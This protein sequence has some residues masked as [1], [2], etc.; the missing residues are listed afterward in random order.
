MQCPLLGELPLPFSTRRGWPHTVETCT[1]PSGIDAPRVTIVTPSFNQGQF[2]EETIR[3]VLLQGYPNLE[4]IV[5][6]GGSTDNSVEIIRRYERWL[7][8]WVSEPD[9]GQASAINKGLCQS[10]GQIMAWLNSDDCLQPGAIWQIVSLFNRSPQTNLVCGYRQVIDAKCRHVRYEA[11]VKPDKFS[12][13]RICYIPQETVYW[14][15]AVWETVGE[16]DES[17]Q[18][19]LDFDYWQRVLLAGYHFDL[20]PRFI[21]L[22]RLHANAKGERSLDVRERELARIHLRYLHSTK[23]EIELR[24]EIS[25]AWWRRMRFLRLLAGLR[26]L[27]VPRLADVVVDALSLKEDAV[28]NQATMRPH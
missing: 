13:S 17:Y 16:L 23:T 3:S 19:A 9:R 11:Y 14:R 8:H 12:L 7:T 27:H 5:I 28:A 18:F 15:R 24:R 2:L 1:R 25:P 4:Y 20:L 21:S 10:T 6:D 22:F 26:L